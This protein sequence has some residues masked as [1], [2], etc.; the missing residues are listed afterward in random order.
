MKLRYKV[1]LIIL[2]V[3]IILGIGGFFCYKSPDMQPIGS[4]F[5][6]MPAWDDIKEKVPFLHPNYQKPPALSPQVSQ[7]L[8][9]SRT[10]ITSYQQITANKENQFLT[11]LKAAGIPVNSVYLLDTNKGEPV[12]LLDF[13]LEGISGNF[14][15]SMV[16]SLT[17]LAD[18]KNLNFAGLNYVTL[19]LR[20]S[21]D[22]IIFEVTARTTDIDRYRSGKITQKDLL[23]ASAAK[24]VS[25]SGASE[26]LLEGV[27]K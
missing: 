13:T 19:G 21:Q 6:W 10:K 23:S 3:V 15:T 7:T 1:W 5:S 16:R 27:V 18:N 26:A 14:M 20:D 17:A 22:R 2:G 25:R 11:Q 8:D 9:Q 4:Y 12:L 24:V